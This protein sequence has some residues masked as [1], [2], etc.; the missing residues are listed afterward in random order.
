MNNI[1]RYLEKVNLFNTYQKWLK[2][3]ALQQAKL[4]LW[5]EKEWYKYTSIPNSTRTWSHKQKILN[6]ITGLNPGLSDLVIIL[7]RKSLLFLEMKREEKSLSNTS[8]WQIQWINELNQ[9]ENIQAE[10]AYWSE[11][12]IEI[13][14]NIEN[15]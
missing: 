5:L 1:G 7:K 6:M 10:I 8:N 12:A 14:K 13:I 4:V 15:S 2:P 9:L 3:E 11:E